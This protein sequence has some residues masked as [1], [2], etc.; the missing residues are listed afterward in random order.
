[1]MYTTAL[2]PAAVSTVSLPQAER[3]PSS[4]DTGSL[5]F[6]DLPVILF[7]TGC[8]LTKAGQDFPG[9]DPENITGRHEQD[10]WICADMTAASVI[11]LIT[12]VVN[13]M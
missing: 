12:I 1:M 6:G 3:G 4:S 5:L 9:N 2:R 11:I 10:G 7:K 8:L 13:R